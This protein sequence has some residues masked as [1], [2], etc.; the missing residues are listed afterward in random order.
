MEDYL[1]TSVND[2]PHMC[3]EPCPSSAT[4][5]EKVPLEE[6]N[7]GSYGMEEEERN[8]VPS[9]SSSTSWPGPMANTV[10]SS[11]SALGMHLAAETALAHGQR[12]K[13]MKVMLSGHP[14]GMPHKCQ[15]PSP[16]ATVLR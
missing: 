10:I 2:R 14:C 9:L 15:S 6:S 13:A 11:A 5:K 4:G 7:F 16:P 3:S 12:R 8:M 1:H